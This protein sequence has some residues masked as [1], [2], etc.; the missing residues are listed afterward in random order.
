MSSE[1]TRTADG[2]KP[3]FY[4]I[5]AV[6]CTGECVGPGC[7]I[8]QEA[9]SFVWRKRLQFDFSVVLLLKPNQACLARIGPN[10]FAFVPS[11]WSDRAIGV[12]GVNAL[13]MP[14]IFPDNLLVLL[15]NLARNVFQ[16]LADQRASFGHI[17]FLL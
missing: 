13:A 6:F 8:L 15:Q 4:G 10:G 12:E 1:Y 3:F 14:D 2:R 17:P 11:A 7:G 5:I 16:V 9:P